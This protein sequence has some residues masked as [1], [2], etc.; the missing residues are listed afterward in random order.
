MSQV[1]YLKKEFE[2]HRQ[3]GSALFDSMLNQTMDGVWFWDLTNPD[4]VWISPRF[5][6]MLGYNPHDKK[7]LANEWQSIVVESDLRI[8]QANFDK[9]LKD[10]SYPYD[11]VIRYQRKDGGIC[12]IRSRGV[13]IYNE[14]NQPSRMLATHSDITPLLGV[15]DEH[16]ATKQIQA[17]NTRLLEA[18]RVDPLTGLMSQ[19]TTLYQVKRHII[20][21]ADRLTPVSIALININNIQS[22]SAHI[23]DQTKNIVLKEIAQ[24]LVDTL[25]EADYLGRMQGHTFLLLMPDTF[26]EDAMIAADRM[27]TLITERRFTANE[28]VACSIGVA[29]Y[30]PLDQGEPKAINP[31]HAL[32]QMLREAGQALNTA[33]S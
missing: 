22:A 31:F 27:R 19:D 2:L 15:L 10:I 11:Q 33:N 8:W 14:Q 1:H 16:H 25:R 9:H 23:G 13:S 26:N 4:H 5:W 6:S 3:Q 29:T 24:A 7:H 32:Q 21:A 12:A 17:I 20:G 18:V 30:S 28:S